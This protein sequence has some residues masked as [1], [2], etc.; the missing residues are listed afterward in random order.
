MKL[1]DKLKARLT[2]SYNDLS[3]IQETETLEQ[4]IEKMKCCSNCKHQY[5][6]GF[7]HCDCFDF[8]AW[9]LKGDE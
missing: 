3:L 6:V 2:F 9:E 7:V 8:S 1:S 5:K 4:Q